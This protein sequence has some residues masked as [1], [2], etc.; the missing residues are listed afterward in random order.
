MHALRT[1]KSLNEVNSKNY[2]PDGFNTHY[3][4]MQHNVSLINLFPHT[5]TVVEA[6]HTYNALILLNQMFSLEECET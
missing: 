6:D 3:G 4:S 5:H 1:K 2:S